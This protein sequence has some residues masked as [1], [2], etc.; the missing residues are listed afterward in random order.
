MDGPLDASWKHNFWKFQSSQAGEWGDKLKDENVDSFTDMQE[1]GGASKSTVQ[2]QQGR[3][4]NYTE[5][6]IQHILGS[7]ST[8]TTVE[9]GSG[10]DS[11]T[12]AQSRRGGR[13]QGSSSPGWGRGVQCTEG[14]QKEVGGVTAGVR[15][16]SLKP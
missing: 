1:W 10:R 4:H 11:C 7:L 13:L 9:T 12:S 14:G 5:K 15:D 16:K 2:S 8:R 6:I 3:L